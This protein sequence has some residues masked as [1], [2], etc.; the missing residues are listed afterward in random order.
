MEPTVYEHVNERVLSGSSF[1]GRVETDLVRYDRIIQAGHMELK[2]KFGAKDVLYL[3][4]RLHGTTVDNKSLSLWL[5]HGLQHLAYDP[6]VD[7]SHDEDFKVDRAE[8]VEKLNNISVMERMALIEH[9]EQIFQ[10]EGNDEKKAFVRKS[11]EG[12]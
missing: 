10:V 7:D 3:A 9:L 8:L 2:K 11:F 4:Q 5:T 12:G 1:S 6:M